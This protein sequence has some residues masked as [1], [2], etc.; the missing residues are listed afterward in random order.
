MLLP[1]SRRR[2]SHPG[3]PVRPPLGAVLFALAA[4]LPAQ[5]P[6]GAPMPQDLASLTATPPANSP[7]ELRWQLGQKALAAGKLEDARGHLREALALHPASAPILLDLVRAAGDDADLREYWSE[8]FVRAAVD[9]RGRL[10]L[11]K[12]IKTTIPA[13][14]LAAAQDLAQKR[15]AAIQEVARFAQKQRPSGRNNAARAELLGFASELLLALGDGCPAP[16]GDAAGKVATLQRALPP[17]HDAVF[18]ALVKVM[19]K[20]A[21]GDDDEALVMQRA[22]RA[23]RILAGLARQATFDDL[24]GPPPPDVES[25][26]EQARE[27]FADLDGRAQA[28]AKVWTIAELEALDDV[29]REQFTTE[30]DTWQHPGVALSET[31]RYRIETI[32]GHGTLL[33]AART[34]EL[35]HARLANHFGRDPFEGRQGT[36]RIVPEASDLET[37]GSPFWWAGGFQSG[38]RTTVRFAWGSIAGLGRLLTHELTHRF[39]GTLHPFVLPWYGEGHAV[40]TAAHY[41]NMADGECVENWL[42]RGPVDWTWRK[43]YGDKDELEK[44]LEGTIEEY[45]DNYQAGYALYAYLRSFPPGPKPRYRD[46]LERFEKNARVGRKDPVGFFTKTFCDGKEGRPA[47]FDE[48]VADWQDFLKG[49]GRWLLDERDDTNRWVGDYGDGPESKD[50]VAYVLDR[51]TWSWARTRAE[52]FFGQDHAAAANRL[53]AEVG[54]DAATV[55]AGLWSLE[56]DG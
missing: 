17:D 51:P 8:R 36:V 14:A 24:K 9:A 15:T 47:S 49:V 43:G 22:I 42:D 26:G 1:R 38:D 35:H 4:L 28:A 21:A 45:R 33:G 16:L 10:K 3:R 37:E 11:D 31:G 53:L 52:P 40:W 23:A 13:D 12:A 46:A 18:D 30:H 48:F 39:D 55:A 41:G 20:T 27:F 34:L 50:S 7:G 19:R 56:V 29:A 54:D 25:L 6:P 2:M 32:C 5:C 44:L